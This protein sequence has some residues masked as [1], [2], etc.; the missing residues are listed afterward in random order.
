VAGIETSL[1]RPKGLNINDSSISGVK[2]QRKKKKAAGSIRRQSFSWV[3]EY[4]CYYRRPPLRE[5]PLPRD[6][7]PLREA[8]LL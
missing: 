7:P 4:Y 1:R 2:T 5:P 6:P 8:P 3:K